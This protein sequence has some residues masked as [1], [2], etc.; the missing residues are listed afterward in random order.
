MKNILLII[1]ILSALTSGVFLKPTHNLGTADMMADVKWQYGF[2]GVPKSD[3]LYISGGTFCVSTDLGVVFLSADSVLSC[4]YVGDIVAGP[5]IIGDVVYVSTHKSVY[6]IGVDGSILDSIAIPNVKDLYSWNNYLVIN[7]VNVYSTLV[8]HGADIELH[9]GII[10]DYADVGNIDGEGTDDLIVCSILGEV[11]GYSW[12]GDV[13]LNVS[14]SLNL[15]SSEFVSDLRV[16]DVSTGGYDEVV[17]G[18]KARYNPNFGRLFVVSSDGAIRSLN[19]S[20]GVEAIYL[21]DFDGD[22]YLDIF[23]G[24]DLWYAIINEGSMEPIY[25]VSTVG[26]EEGFAKPLVIRDIDGDGAAEI[27]YL[28]GKGSLVIGNT[29]AVEKIINVPN[30][31]FLSFAVGEDTTL[32]LSREGAVYK[33]AENADAEYRFSLIPSM[34]SVNPIIYG[35]SSILVPL[36]DGMLLFGSKQGDINITSGLGALADTIYGDVDGDGEDEA[37]LIVRSNSTT[38]IYICL[39]YTSPSPRDRG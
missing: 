32:I 19:L 38:E 12:Y 20:R 18:T 7:S 30:Q 11:L 22:G 5:L 28:G 14:I 4:A 23:V 31:P 16:G 25:N 15:G 17:L 26:Y 8:V 35:D 9:P 2:H 13:I 33:L 10:V 39:L 21:Y 24:T 34:S 36:L 1:I 27:L 37:V 3:I 6:K 29:T